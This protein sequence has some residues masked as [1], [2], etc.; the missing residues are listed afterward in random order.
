MRGSTMGGND[1]LGMSGASGS[2]SL[3]SDH[4]DESGVTN[5]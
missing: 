5:G 2:A 4:C 3:S 1:V